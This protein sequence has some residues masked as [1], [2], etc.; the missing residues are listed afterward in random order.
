MHRRL[1][2]FDAALFQGIGDFGRHVVLIVF[3]QNGIGSETAGGA[4]FSLSNNALSFPKQVGKNAG[5]GHL[6][7]LDRIGNSEGDLCPFTAFH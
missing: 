6:N 5:I 1:P 4:E 7:R 2:E 3:C